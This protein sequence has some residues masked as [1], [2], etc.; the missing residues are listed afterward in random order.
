MEE[1]IKEIQ[2]QFHTHEE[3]YAQYVSACKNQEALKETE[4]SK[5]KE[6][7]EESIKRVDELE[8]KVKEKDREIEKERQA[9]K[10]HMEQNIKFQR[11][12]ELM[13][14]KQQIAPSLESMPSDQKDAAM[15]EVELQKYRSI[16]RCSM[17]SF[18][19][20]NVV[21]CKCMHSFC[22]ECIKDWMANRNRKCPKCN[23]KFSQVDVKPLWLDD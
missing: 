9:N 12:N 8:K 14:Q 13:K 2:C 4:I 20:K 23:H 21:L 22:N 1:S 11:E 6:L 3:A 18:R 10:R 17:C 15:R 7:N 19:M 5:L 16:V